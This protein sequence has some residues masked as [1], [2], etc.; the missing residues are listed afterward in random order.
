MVGD[1]STALLYLK[2]AAIPSPSIDLISGLTKITT[3]TEVSDVLYH[4]SLLGDK[5][6][7]FTC[8]ELE[9]CMDYHWIATYLQMAVIT[10]IRSNCKVTTSIHT[11]MP[12]LKLTA[13][14]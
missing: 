4:S 3:S 11:L 10:A 8:K 9:L 12:S 6:A 13:G 1:S 7:I 5:I 14:S 2:K